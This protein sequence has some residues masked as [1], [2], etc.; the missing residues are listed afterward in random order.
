L[1]LAAED[2][3]SF[4]C[5]IVSALTDVTIRAEWQPIS[6]IIGSTQVQVLTFTETTGDTQVAVFTGEGRN[7]GEF[8]L[9]VSI[10][11]PGTD[12][13]M[14]S[15]SVI[16]NVFDSRIV[17]EDSLIIDDANAFN[18]VMEMPIIQAMIGALVLF[19]LMGMLMIRGKASET[20]MAEQRAERAREVLTARYNRINDTSQ[21][22]HSLDMRGGVPPPPPPPRA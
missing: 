7:A 10:R 13:A 2:Y 8:Q 20:R 1:D 17:D 11:E 18:K 12:V 21:V 19:F 3:F 6:S 14:D 5:S 22:R 16:L 9:F 15:G 4:S